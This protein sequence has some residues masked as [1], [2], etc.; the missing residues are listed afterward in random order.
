MH[1]RSTNASIRAAALSSRESTNSR[2]GTRSLGSSTYSIVNSPLI[3]TLASPRCFYRII[4]ILGVDGWTAVG[5]ANTTKT[6]NDLDRSAPSRR[7]LATAFSTNCSRQARA[8]FSCSAIGWERNI[9]IA[10]PSES[11]ESTMLYLYERPVPDS[12]L[13][14]RPQLS[15]N[16]RLPVTQEVAG[17]SRVTLISQVS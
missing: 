6:R 10:L 1:K 9:L 15:G 11:R 4:A 2:A 3:S 12:P 16:E 13:H 17:S 14:A 5:A 8:L 7:T